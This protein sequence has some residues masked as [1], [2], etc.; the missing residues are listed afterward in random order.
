LGEIIFRIGR[1]REATKAN[2]EYIFFQRRQYKVV[3][4]A[5]NLKKFCIAIPIFLRKN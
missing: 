5:Q 2:M 4:A 1:S 3:L